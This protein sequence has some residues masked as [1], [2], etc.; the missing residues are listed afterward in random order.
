[1]PRCSSPARPAPARSSSRAPSMRRAAR[2]DAVLVKL[3]C[4]AIPER[5]V[6]SELFGHEKGAFTGAMAA[7]ARPLRAGAI[8]GRCSSTRSAS[9][10]LDAAAQAACA[11]LQ[12]RRV[13]ARGRHGDPHGRRAHHRRH[14]PRPR[15][16]VAGGPVPRRPVL[17]PQCVPHRPPRATRAPGRS[18]GTGRAFR[19]AVR[20]ER[21][22]KPLET[23]PPAFMRRSRHTTGPA[24]CASWSTSSNAP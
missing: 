5:L 18:A 22:G 11:S 23:V 10:P 1:M 17:P 21:Y 9:C 4:A 7:Q 19:A 13:R 12:E 15:E 14:Q 24:M 20:A 6:E 8:G 2:K 3:N 16:K